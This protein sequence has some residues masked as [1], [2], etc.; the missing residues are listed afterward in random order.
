MRQALLAGVGFTALAIGSALAADTPPT[1]YTSPRAPTPLPYFCRNGFDL[2][3][4]NCNA[5]C[6]GG[7]PFDV[8]FRSHLIR[9]GLNFRF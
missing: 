5:A 6:S 2:G 4:D 9:G 1:R 8:A 7:N 3:K